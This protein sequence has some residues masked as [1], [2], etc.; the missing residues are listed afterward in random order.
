[1][2]YAYAG[3]GQ[4]GVGGS[5]SIAFPT[6]LNVIEQV[7]KDDTSIADPRTAI[8]IFYCITTPN[9]QKEFLTVYGDDHGAPVQ[10]ANHF[11]S[12]SGSEEMSTSLEAWA[13][14]R[15]IDA[16][17]AWTFSGDATARQIAL[18]NGTAV[19]T[20]VGQWS[21]GVPVQP[22]GATDIPDPADY[23]PGP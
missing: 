14:V 21:D 17:A 13:I 8:D 1:P 6:N 5:L 7:F 2:S 11:L 3:G 22:M 4:T 10:V 20:F 16:L 23:A 12:N 18:G 19:E 15:H 9:S